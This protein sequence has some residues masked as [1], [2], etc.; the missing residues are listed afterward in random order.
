MRKPPTKSVPLTLGE[1]NLLQIALELAALK[2]GVPADQV[3]RMVSL[4]TKLRQYS[5][6]LM[7]VI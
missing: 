5:Q 1:L 6:K 3:A 2:R 7:E 4:Q